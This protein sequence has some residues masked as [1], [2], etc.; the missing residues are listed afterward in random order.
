VFALVKHLFTF[1]HFRKTYFDIDDFTKKLKV[2]TSRNK[3]KWLYIYIETHWL[4]MNAHVPPFYIEPFYCIVDLQLL[5]LPELPLTSDLSKHKHNL[6]ETG[7]CENM[8]L[9]TSP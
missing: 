5:L 4:I 1:F 2:S 8:P 3:D 9:S 6:S 7:Y